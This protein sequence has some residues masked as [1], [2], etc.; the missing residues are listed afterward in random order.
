MPVPQGCTGFGT[1]TLALSPARR[2][3]HRDIATLNLYETY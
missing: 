3:R 1:E 2:A